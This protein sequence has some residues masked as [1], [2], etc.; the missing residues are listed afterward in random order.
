MGFENLSGRTFG[1]YELR[2][3]MGVGG[4]GAVYR[5]YQSG[6]DREVAVKVLPRALAAE[7]GYI[8]RFIREARTAALLEHPHIVRIYDYGT[9]GDIS[10]LVMALLRGGSLSQRLSQREEVSRP[11]ASLGEVA[12]MLNQI[13]SALDYAH[14]E[15]V[16]HRDIKPANIMFDNQGRA[17]VTDFGIAKLM[18][19][20]TALTGTGVAM[21]SPSYM[22]PEQ[23]AGQEIT[24][25]ADQY[26]LGVT[27]YQTIAGRLPFEA[28][29]AAQLMYKHFHEEPTPLSVSR[30]D[31]PTSLMLVL[32]RSMAKAPEA[33]FPNVTQFAQSFEGAIE[34][35][36]GDATNFFLYK[37]KSD[38]PRPSGAVPTP[39][40]AEVPRTPSNTGVPPSPTSG[41]YPPQPTPGA[42]VYAQPS[43]RQGGYVPPTQQGQP[44]SGAYPPGAYPPA[45]TPTGG[46][47]PGTTPSGGYTMPYVQAAPKPWY[48]N[49][50]ALIGALVVVIAAVAI[51]A[52]AL[53]PADNSAE[54]VFLTLTSVAQSQ[55]STSQQQTIVAAL[56]TDTPSLEPSITPESV[57]TNTPGVVDPTEEP[58]SLIVLIPTDTSEPAPS[59]TPTDVPATETPTDLPTDAPTFTATD[60]A[61]EAPTATATDTATNTPEP[62]ATQTSDATATETFTPRPTASA[63]HTAT[64]TPEPRV[65]GLLEPGSV[66]SE[67]INNDTPEVLFTFEG[68]A[69]QVIT[70]TVNVTSGNLD[71]SI[72]L[73]GP[74]GDEVASND[75]VSGTDRNAAIPDLTLPLDG[76]YVVSVLRFRGPRGQSAGSFELRFTENNGQTGDVLTF[77]TPVEGSI[78][79]VIPEVDYVFEASAGSIVSVAI[80][81]TSGNLDTILELYGPDGALLAENDD[82]TGGTTNSIIDQFHAEAG[83]TYVVRAARFRAADGNTTGDF[84][85]TVSEGEP[86]GP[87]DS[88]VSTELFAGESVFGTIDA[89]HPRRVYT[90]AGTAGETISI[91]LAALDGTLDPLLR[92]LN[93]DGTVL[94]ENDDAAVGDGNSLV[95]GIDLPVDGVYT[96]IATRYREDAGE[97]VGRF[98]LA[99]S[100]GSAVTNNLECGAE[101]RI[102]CPAVVNPAMER[103]VNVRG[104]PRASGTLVTSLAAG[105]SVTILDGPRA[106]EGFIWWQVQLADGTQGWMVQRIGF[107]DV[108]LAGDS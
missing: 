34:G 41:Y 59:E 86:A 49:P 55:I 9:Q 60:T 52:V 76:T 43:T 48:S 27:I 3:L 100:R 81:A 70:L 24:P 51:A 73:Y 19:A 21:G 91:A 83:G 66:V 87:P 26:A 90:Y 10:Y 28:D 33:R 4:M 72:V 64:L 108:L 17:Y 7:T 57:V 89:T 40:A 88:L 77:G 6:L 12:I 47:L 75:D 85:L 20:T 42:P 46:Y 101:L 25:A 13:A 37:L 69:A 2:D 39:F 98:E 63:T 30:S 35:S 16:L 15:G 95:A 92:V 32:N 1:Q 94:A 65:L 8:E 45:A 61:T 22:P 93:P 67:T 104:E 99:V 84:V 14:H 58:T 23:W 79:D 107:N 56:A 105:S 96:V 106:S 97:T 50:I 78:S 31:I 38:K 54:A 29:S 18:G 80:Y 44:P 11:R 103:A 5:A 82:A 74:N 71:P 68:R 36:Q 102:G 62:T 53:R